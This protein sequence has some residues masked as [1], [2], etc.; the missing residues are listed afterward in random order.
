MIEKVFVIATTHVE[1]A[2]TC[3]AQAQ[4]T[5]RETST[6]R[7]VF[8]NVVSGR[9]EAVTVYEQFGPGYD[10]YISTPK[11]FEVILSNLSPSASELIHPR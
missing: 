3:P 11:Y 5:I 9:E 6:R 7:I 10:A 2:S 4:L 1:N 8:D